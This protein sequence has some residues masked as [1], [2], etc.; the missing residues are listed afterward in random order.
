MSLKSF[1]HLLWACENL[2]KKHNNLMHY[3]DVILL[4]DIILAF[5]P[6]VTRWVTYV[7]YSVLLFVLNYTLYLQNLTDCTL[8]H[9][10]GPNECSLHKLLYMYICCT[11]NLTLLNNKLTID[12]IR[13]SVFNGKTQLIEGYKHKWHF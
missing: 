7:T 3:F 4:S 1:L 6:K 12:E 11:A 13:N 10:Y 5:G 9:S 2:L 8:K